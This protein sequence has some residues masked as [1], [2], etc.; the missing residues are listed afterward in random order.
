MFQT[1]GTAEQFSQIYGFVLFLYAGDETKRVRFAPVPFFIDGLPEIELLTV[2]SEH[3]HE[4]GPCVSRNCV[5]AVDV[6]TAQTVRVAL[7]S[8]KYTVRFFGKSLVDRDRSGC[9]EE[10]VNYPL[11]CLNERL[12]AYYGCDAGL[13]R[14]LGAGKMA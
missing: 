10:H 8:Y 2:F 7:V 3:V 9:S 11:S 13:G 1:S 6:Q 4:H 14:H 5:A 12:H